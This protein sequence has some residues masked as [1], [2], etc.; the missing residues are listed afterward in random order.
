VFKSGIH[1]T[2]AVVA[3]ALTITLWVMP[4]KPEDATSPQHQFEHAF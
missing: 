4:G 3:F 2:L 1:L